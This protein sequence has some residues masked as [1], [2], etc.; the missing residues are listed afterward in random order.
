MGPSRALSRDHLIATRYRIDSVLGAGGFGTVYRATDTLL[1]RAVALK[2]IEAPDERERVVAEAR[3]TARL[4]HPAII[5]VFDAGLDGPH[6]FLAMELIDGESLRAQLR[7]D[8]VPLE[9]RLGWLRTIADAL[10]A[11]HEGGIVHLDVKPE[12]IF[13][14][15]R[16]QIKVGDFGLAL[17]IQPGDAV[18][19][20]RVAGTP[21]YMAPEQLT[22]DAIDARADQY[23]W[24]IVAFELLAGAHPRA[25]RPE[26]DHATVALH[27]RPPDLHALGASS[28][29]IAAVVARA[30][31]K[32]PEHRFL[33]MAALIRAWDVA[34]ATADAATAP[35]APRALIDATTETMTDPPRRPTD[36]R[37]HGGTR[38][39]TAGRDVPRVATDARTIAGRA[40]AR[41]RGLARLVIPVLALGLV[42]VVAFA[43]AR[44]LAGDDAPAGTTPAADAGVTSPALPARALPAPPTVAGPGSASGSAAVKPALADGCATNADC[45]AS[46]ICRAPRSGPRRCMRAEASDKFQPKPPLA[47]CG[48]GKSAACGQPCTDTACGPRTACIYPTPEDLR[49]GTNGVCRDCPRGDIYVAKASACLR[50][51]AT[52]LDCPR[53]WTCSDLLGPRACYAGLTSSW[54]KR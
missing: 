37:N 19:R 17:A 52:E 5:T 11:A 54:E 8:A 44:P 36:A 7:R 51:C 47:T 35:Q 29:A 32:R 33:S 4:D 39:H 45:R 46:E 18:E 40:P 30:L 48:A 9:T 38:A 42:G 31:A 34:T 20:E 16:Q 13:V 1:Q 43:I 3:A 25:L 14:T 24:G 53:G 28:P 10:A 21:G 15:R 50:P 6:A 12:N 49:A 22:A 26:L 27:E 2:I 23:A 41:A